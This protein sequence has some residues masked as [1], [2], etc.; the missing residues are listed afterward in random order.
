[1]LAAQINTPVIPGD[2]TF[3]MHNKAGTRKLTMCVN[4]MDNGFAPIDS[5]QF[6]LVVHE[7]ASQLTPLTA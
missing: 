4:V 2:S 7:G 3:V 6:Q 5:A 1:M